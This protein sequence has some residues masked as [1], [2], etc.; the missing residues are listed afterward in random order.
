MRNPDEIASQA[1]EDELYARAM[2]PKLISRPPADFRSAVEKDPRAQTELMARHI[3]DH[4]E[5]NYLSL[6]P[7]HALELL[8]GARMAARDGEPH[9][10]CRVEKDLTNVF[11][12]LRNFGSAEGALSRA[13]A[14]ADRT[15]ANG[16]HHGMVAYARMGLLDSTD[17]PEE[18]L[19]S[20]EEAIR[21]FE[22]NGAYDRA[23][24]V[25]LYD[26]WMKSLAGHYAQ[27]LDAYEDAAGRALECG[28]FECVASAYYNIGQ[29][30]RGLSEFAAA[31]NYFAKAAGIFGRIGSPSL[32]AVSL[33]CLAR[34]SIRMNGEAGIADMDVAKMAFLGTET[35][36]EVC[37][38][39]LAIME[40]LL[41]H[42][43]LSDLNGHYR[44]LESEALELGVLNVGDGAI[45]RLKEA[46]Q[47][48]RVTKEALADAWEAFGPMAGISALAMV[49]N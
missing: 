40:E 27:A 34:M 42:D 25:R 3:L 12:T 48:R 19:Q 2:F 29:C 38:S 6:P 41:F 1:V 21:T 24:M 32:E 14:F 44:L 16:V 22:K 43:P 17:H 47:V 13:G 5:E 7:E 35:G 33:R 39:T 46:I 8:M 45:Y 15:L 36:G 37:R 10:R 11:R 28:S 18:A 31:K 23:H 4:Y 20:G 30:Y 49:H 26:A 9:V